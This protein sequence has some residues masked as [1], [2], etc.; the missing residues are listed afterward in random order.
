MNIKVHLFWFFFSISMQIA[1][2]FF[3]VICEPIVCVQWHWFTALKFHH[4]ELRLFESVTHFSN[5]HVASFTKLNLHFAYFAAPKNYRIPWI[6]RETDFAGYLPCDRDLHHFQAHSRHRHRLDSTHFDSWS[7]NPVSFRRIHSPLASSSDDQLDRLILFA[8][9]KTQNEMRNRS[10][11]ATV[12]NYFHFFMG[13][14][15]WRI[16]KLNDGF[17]LS[18]LKNIRTRFFVHS[19]Y[20]LTWWIKRQW[21]DWMARE[22]WSVTVCME[23]RT[24]VSK[25]EFS[26]M[27]KIREAGFVQTARRKIHW[28]AA[29]FPCTTKEWSTAHARQLFHS[30]LFWSFVLKPDLQTIRK[31]VD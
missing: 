4:E 15:Y 10:E 23:W 26:F 17:A 24:A 3:C 14:F 12:E 18:K 2:H 5:A 29:H 1:G 25:F 27:A 6:R 21:S 30:S 22:K 11:L 8:K 9:R 31:C 13:T 28:K 16:K 19:L 7:S 20:S